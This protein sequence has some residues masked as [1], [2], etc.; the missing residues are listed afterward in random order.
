MISARLLLTGLLVLPTSGLFAAAAAPS[1]ALSQA[2]RQF[3]DFY[4]GT[5][6][7]FA[8]RDTNEQPPDPD[9]ALKQ[10]Q[11]IQPDG[12]WADIDY[13][14]TARSG[15]PPSVH[16]MRMAAMATAAG[17]TATT[18][19]QRTALLATTHRAFAFWIAHDF[20]C[21]NWWYNEI[22]TPKLLGLCALLLGDE[23]T[24]AERAYVT[25][26][27]LTRSKI[28]RTG[29]NR[30]WLAG[31]TLM[32]G[33]LLSD[34]ALVREA[35]DTIWGEVRVS[36]DE[37]IQ[38]DFSFHQHGPQQQFGNYGMAFAVEICR[39]GVF[40]RDTPWQMPPGPLAV[41]R[42]Y[43]LDG[44]N[45][46]SWRGTMDISACGRQFMPH[47]PRAKTTNIA[48]V[49]KLAALFDPAEAPAYRAFVARNQPG[50]ANDLVGQRMFWRSDYL[51]HRRPGFAATLKFSSQRVIG[52]ELVNSENL[53]GYHT[54]DGALYL[55]ATGDEYED[56]FPV[57]DWRKLPGTTCAQIPPPAFQTSAVRVEF[58]GGVTDGR[59]GCAALD[60]RR[61]G[62][63]ARKAWFFGDDVVVCLGAG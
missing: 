32:R 1:A 4:C 56:I 18:P 25:G 54:A 10:A 58:A 60:Y 57:W 23:L 29:Q 37:G 38:P 16:Y 52:A 39:W 15:W 49:M 2:T 42:R 47:S 28:A 19:A 41:F 45:W 6:D 17:W 53:S 59:R 31:N 9:Q 11:A 27:V 40:L 26:P 22:G 20:Q 33:L 46:V 55:Y 5:S 7:A 44:Q 13:Q 61:D 8:L 34:E 62:V 36:T 43:L 48:M 14:S 21:P 3:R 12:S 50:A 35:A 63:Q 30:V 24:A 51:V